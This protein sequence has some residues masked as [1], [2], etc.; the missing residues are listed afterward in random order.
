V[1]GSEIVTVVRKPAK[2]TFGNRPGGA[3]TQWQVPGWQFAPGPSVEAGEGSGQVD[4]DG[5]L[6][7]PAV[8][9]VDQVVPGGI[10]PTDHIIVR[11]DTYQVVGR[12]QDWGPSGCVIVLRLVT[13]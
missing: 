13:G 5:T 10:Q 11:G 6:Y 9:D 2:D 12:V 3:A 1:A 4:T 7:G 8:T